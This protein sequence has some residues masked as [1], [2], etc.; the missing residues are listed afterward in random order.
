MTVLT[1]LFLLRFMWTFNKFDDVFLLTGGAAGTRTLPIEVY[2]NAFGRS[3]IGAGSATSVLLF[4]FLGIFLV[5]YFRTTP[6]TDQ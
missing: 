2:D 4:I 1:T 3:D 6:E 5:I